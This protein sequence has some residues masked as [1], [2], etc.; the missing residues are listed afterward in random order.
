MTK[1]YGRDV[2]DEMII[3]LFYVSSV[4]AKHKLQSLADRGTNV[5]KES[6]F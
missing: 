2:E 1:V 5:E 6:L 3:W 4:R